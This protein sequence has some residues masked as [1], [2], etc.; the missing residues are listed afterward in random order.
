MTTTTTATARQTFALFCAT[1]KD[2]RAT[3]PT[4][5]QASVMLSAIQGLRGNKPA[6]L[7][8]ATRIFQGENVDVSTLPPVDSKPNFKNVFDEAHEAGLQAAKDCKP[9]PMI[10]PGYAP[11]MGGVCGFA[12]VHFKDGR[13]PFPRWLIKKGLADKS[14][15]GG[16]D[17][18]AGFE[19]GGQSMTIQ[20]AYCRAFAEVCN[21]HGITA[22][23]NSRI[24]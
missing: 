3:N 7:E 14:Y 2:W 21:K 5:E 13:K 4:H 1:G 6:A 23:M 9:E 22:R 17:Y 18:Y 11:V 12:W 19:I 20:E 16:T 15:Y 8:L 10:I 24:D